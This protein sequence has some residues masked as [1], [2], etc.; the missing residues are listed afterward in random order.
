MRK[1]ELT[2][3]ECEKAWVGERGLWRWARPDRFPIQEAYSLIPPTKLTAL[4]NPTKER[5]LATIE[6][7]PLD[8]FFLVSEHL[9]LP[10]VLA[11]STA[12]SKP[13]R[14]TL[15]PVLDS[16]VFASLRGQQGWLVPPRELVDGKEVGRKGVDGGF[17]WV[18][19][20][21]ACRKNPNMRC[22]KRVW[23]VVRELGK[24][25]LG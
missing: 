19:Y 18:A 24:V 1:A 16:L 2:Q 5:E 10:E 8:I 7:L 13:L 22:R 14:T 4:Q 20:A 11:L 17:P 25:E 6:T 21:R 12:T 15:I 23:E 3:E 9:P